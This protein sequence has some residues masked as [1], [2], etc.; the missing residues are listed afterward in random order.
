MHFLQAVG[1]LCRQGLVKTYIPRVKTREALKGQIQFGRQMAR[2][3]RGIVGF[4]TRAAEYERGHMLNRLLLTALHTVKQSRLSHVTQDLLPEV[5]GYFEGVSPLENSTQIISALQFDRRTE[6]YRIAIDLAKPILLSAYPGV[7]SGVDDTFSMF[8]DM[9]KVWERYIFCELR[10]HAA[11]LGV[12]VDRQV[13]A[14]FWAGRTVRPD[15]VVYLDGGRQVVIDTKW[16][17]LQRPE[18]A[19]GD[20]Y[21]MFIYNHQVKA[22]HS[23]L[24]YPDIHGLEGKGARFKAPEGLANHGCSVDFARAWREHEGTIVLNREVGREVWGMVEASLA[25][26]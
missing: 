13:S 1:D 23:I 22:V 5:L 16:K 4:D 17:E 19:D 25:G 18:P 7:R 26:S 9:N 15:I 21:Q 12:R 14:S 11:Q 2:E 20:L 8:F 10:R 24:L 3:V 6:R